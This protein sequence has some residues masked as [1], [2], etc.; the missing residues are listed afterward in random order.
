M[1]TIKEYSS[2]IVEN[3]NESKDILYLEK[4]CFRYNT[5]APYKIRLQ[6][7]NKV[8][9]E[10]TS[11]A[12]IIQLD[13]V[14]IHFSTKVKT[15]LFYMLSFLKDEQ[16]FHYD[17]ETI[18]DIKEGA[19]FFDILGRMFLNELDEILKRG[20]Y[21]GYVRRQ[22][23][24]KFL[25][26][27]LIFKKQLQ[28]D[29]NKNAKLYCS[30]GDL[31]F[32]NLEN[33]ILLKATTLL[34]PLIKFNEQ[35]KRDLVRYSF[36]LREEV[37]LVNVLPEDC[38]KVQYSRLNDYYETIIK[39]AKVIL[40]N[41]FIRSTYEGA[42]KGFNFIVNMNKVYEDFITALIEEIVSEDIK[43]KTFIVEKQKRF[44]SLFRERAI[45]TKPDVILRKKD[46][47]QYPVIIDA[48]YKT[49]GSNADYFQVTSYALAIPT[50]KACYLIYPDSEQVEVESLTIPAA[51]FGH[52]R[53]D[54]KFYTI[55]INL[56]LNEDL[57]FEDYISK[58][59]N[60]ITRGLDKVN[61]L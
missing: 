25:K 21:K 58:V 57:K 6:R 36:L 59:K 14:R 10:N 56:F 12:G 26:G 24:I 41:Y 23:N 9:I 17:P 7:D 18:I 60:E 42:A 33:Q 11:Y 45:I 52:T 8:A 1:I 43:F 30:Y 13:K 3:L 44:D 40:Q 38:D 34:I 54:I 51:Q 35:I 29:I 47:D 53:P 46:T 20:F 2:S 4:E 22:E 61:T 48:K 19:N 15:N 16:S 32:D 39:F 49:K 37:N 31:T 5:L 28:N 50:T 27:K 55:K